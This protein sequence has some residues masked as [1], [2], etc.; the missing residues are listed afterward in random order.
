MGWWN[1]LGAALLVVGVAAVALSAPPAGDARRT[2]STPTACVELSDELLAG[3]VLLGLVDRPSGAA[4]MVREGALAGVAPFGSV[5]AAEAEELADLR[6]GDLPY[7]VLVA[8]DEE[9]GR[10][11]RFAGLLGALPSAADMARTMTPEA[12]VTTFAAHGQRLRAAG[13]D[14]AFAPVVDVGGGP[15]IGDRSF[16]DDPAVV[17]AYGAALVEG[18]RSAGVLPVLKHFPGHGRA[19]AD[20]H[21]GAAVVPPV[22]ELRLVDLVPFQAL[23]DGGGPLGVMVGHLEVPGLTDGV[24]ASLSGAAV[25]GL[26][27]GDL[28][29]DGLVV[30]DALGMGAIAQRYTAGD[31]AVRF[32][33]AGGDLAVVSVADV[34]AARSAIVAALRDGVLDRA[35]LQA[36]VARVMAAKHLDPCT[37]RPVAPTSTT[38]STSSS[39]SMST[40]S[41]TSMSTSTTATPTTTM[42]TSVPGSSAPPPSSAPD[43]APAAESERTAVAVVAAI[44]AVGVGVLATLLLVRRRRGS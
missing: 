7:G 15:A 1:R 33:S 44:V 30:S 19:S 22:D 39:T 43:T 14:M 26:L 18:Y 12:V 17:T 38:S 9:G 27:R 2:A 29:F 31:A 23:I 35:R 16:G 5:S 6:A 21:D 13:V 4:A 40:S 28:G 32:L 8:A 25:D 10:V 42:P 3:Q 11:Q 41:S 34:A 24:P 36:S 37:L 20:T